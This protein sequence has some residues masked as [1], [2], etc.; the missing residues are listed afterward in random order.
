MMR[1]LACVA[2]F[3]LWCGAMLA[4]PAHARDSLG[5]FEG[6]GAF[7]DA[8]TPRCYAIAEPEDAAKS[9]APSPWRAFVSVANWPRQGIRGQ[10]HARLS[11][12]RSGKGGVTLQIGDRRFALVGGNADAWAADKRADAAIVGAMRSAETMTVSGPGFTDSYTLRGVATAMDAAALGCA[13]L[14]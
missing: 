14:R 7:R 11:R 4:G 5:I 10:F 12:A 8:A 2:L 1:L 13:G 6:W 3:T 9:P